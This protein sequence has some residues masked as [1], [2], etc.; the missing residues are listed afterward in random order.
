MNQDDDIHK[1]LFGVRRSIRYHNRRRDFFDTFNQITTAF[2]L[3]AGSATVYGVLHAPDSHE[4]AIWSGMVVT[5]LSAF[6]LVVGSAR[7]ARLHHDLSKKFIT[8]EKKMLA[9][10][11]QIK[12]WQTERLDIEAEEP[13]VLRVLD[14]ICHNEMLRSM[15]YNDEHFAEIAWYQR[16]FAQFFDI[17]DYTIKPG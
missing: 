6:N 8:L 17:R 5:V 15:G 14:C 10:D 2:S 4:L 12:E 7:Q 11:G 1:L 13:P 9:E 3:I 16:W